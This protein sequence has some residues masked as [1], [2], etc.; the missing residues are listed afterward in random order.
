MP[1]FSVIRRGRE[2]A[3]AQQA[4]DAAKAKGEDTAKVPYKHIPTHAAIDAMYGAPNAF[5]EF[6]RAIILEQN[7]RRS[8]MSSNGASIKSMPRHG[9]SLSAVSYPSSKATPVISRTGSFNN[10]PINPRLRANINTTYT[11]YPRSLK[12]RG[13]EVVPLISSTVATPVLASDRTGMLVG[14]GNAPS[15]GLLVACHSL[16]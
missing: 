3:K 8:A 9:S 16:Q 14:K 5:K 1:L 6:D 13:R 2:Q 4:K 12:G 10:M 7:R 11:S 15:P